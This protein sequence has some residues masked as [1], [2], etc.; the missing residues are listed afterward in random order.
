MEYN[1]PYPLKLTK[2]IHK[3]DKYSLQFKS[4]FT[5]FNKY[6]FYNML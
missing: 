4:N 3:N 6:Y 1:V 2:I 5:E